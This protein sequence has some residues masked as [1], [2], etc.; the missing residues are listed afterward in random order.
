MP[1]ATKFQQK[2]PPQQEGA[3]YATSC[4]RGQDR[5]DAGRPVFGYDKNSGKQRPMSSG[6]VAQ[7]YSVG[8]LRFSP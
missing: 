4:Y 6:T 8:V 7:R 1:G 3:S 5:N 2:S